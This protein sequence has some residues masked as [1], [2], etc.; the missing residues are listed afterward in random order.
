MIFRYSYQDTWGRLKLRCQICSWLQF[1]SDPVVVL[2]YLQTICWTGEVLTEKPPSLCV[3]VCLGFAHCSNISTHRNPR[4]NG[5]AGCKN[6]L[7]YLSSKQKS[8]QS[9]HSQ[10][11]SHADAECHLCPYGKSSS[12]YLSIF[13]METSSWKQTSSRDLCFV[14]ILKLFWLL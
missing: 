8:H 11:H 3:C 10:G 6:M 1:K 14:I 12:E 7:Q 5:A 9:N 4:R 13:I 2:I